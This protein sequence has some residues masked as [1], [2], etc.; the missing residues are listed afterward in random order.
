MQI[1][2]L[3]DASGHQVGRTVTGDD[4]SYALPLSAGGVYVLIVAGEHV[5]PAAGE[6]G[7]RRPST[8]T[9]DVTLSGGASVS[10]AGGHALACRRRHAASCP[11]TTRH[12]GAACSRGR[13]DGDLW[14]GLD[15]AVVTLTDARGEVVA[16]T[17][18]DDRGG[19]AFPDLVGGS[20]VLTA[21]VTGRRPV[22]SA[23]TVPDVGATT[24][25]LRVPAGGSLRGA[26]TASGD[27]R[28]VPEASVTLVDAGR[29]RGRRHQDG[30][31]RGLLL[32]GDAGGDLH[33]DR[34]RLRAGGRRSSTSAR[35][36]WRRCSSGSARDR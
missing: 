5:R 12:G 23:V 21:Q 17:V 36:R 2:T 18:S 33:D 31:R 24:C 9:R 20:Y 4:G 11:P 29:H 7:G 14:E 16:S 26:V 6:R 1:I 10:G 28:G 22:A 32:R 19:Y 13:S 15:S 8:A 30:G 3:T 27:G 34:G 25:E 35:T